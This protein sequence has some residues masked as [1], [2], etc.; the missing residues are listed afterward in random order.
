MKAM[1]YPGVAY[2]HVGTHKTG[3]TSIQAFLGANEPRFEAAGI[4]LPKTGRSHPTFAA[5][6]NV[7]WELTG[8]PRFDSRSG[9]FDEL[10]DEVA[11]SGL[12][13]A[14]ISAEDF[15]LLHA[16]PG[17]L[18]R[19]G[20]GLRKIGYM[21]KIVVYLRP[22]VDYCESLYAELVRGGWRIALTEML[23]D[24]FAEAPNLTLRFDYELMLRAFASEVGSRAVIV[25][26]YEANAE[27]DRLLR[28]VTAIVG[29]DSLVRQFAT[30]DRPPRLNERETFGAV[31]GAV[32]RVFGSVTDIEETDDSEGPFEP[33][34]VRDI[35]AFALRFEIGNRRIARDYGAWIPTVS[36]RRLAGALRD[37]LG[38]D[39]SSRLRKRAFEGLRAGF[40]A[41][42]R[43][44]PMAFR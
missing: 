36:P 44:A 21:P 16:Y 31:C 7:A 17:A 37:L 9:T 29:G 43:R 33:L 20:S 14:C 41:R 38:L 10:L 5:Q 28:D 40:P 32:A 24:L 26:S 42:K 18:M 19:L 8:D 6:P 12:P 25:R 2:V 15:D 27:E 22:Q 4:V 34:T 3:T 13:T 35:A 39:A 11:A 1:A 23:D 30:F